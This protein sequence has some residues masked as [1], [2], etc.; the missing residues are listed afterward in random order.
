MVSSTTNNITTAPAHSNNKIS[1]QHKIRKSSS[2]GRQWLTGSPGRTN[3]TTNSQ[4]PTSPYSRLHPQHYQRAAVT[5]AAAN[6]GGGVRRSSAAGIIHRPPLPPNNTIGTRSHSLDG[7]LDAAAITKTAAGTAKNNAQQEHTE[8]ASEQSDI[9]NKN[10]VT[11]PPIHGSDDAVDSVSA[12]ATIT[13]TNHR[14]SRSMEDLLD[15]QNSCGDVTDIES[16][17]EDQSK[18]MENLIDV[19]AQTSNI[20]N[21]NNTDKVNDTFN[22]KDVVSIGSASSINVTGGIEQPCGSESITI[23][24]AIIVSPLEKPLLAA[25]PTQSSIDDSIGDDCDTTSTTPSAYSRQGSTTSSKD[26]GKK[27]TFL[28]R[29]VKKVKSFIKK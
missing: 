23:D 2:P 18:S 3:T 14:R 7:L 19:A 27:K 29:Y 1:P 22:Y 21:H 6:R 28:N 12:A 26:S 4:L 10:N 8:G 24:N 5:N 9:Y 16:G 13:S 11:L 25:T 17:C 20:A 15:E